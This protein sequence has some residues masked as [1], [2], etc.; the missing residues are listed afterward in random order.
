VLMP[1]PGEQM[2]GCQVATGLTWTC[3]YPSLKK[4]TP[5]ASSITNSSPA[6]SS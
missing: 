5:L 4:N 3:D 1:I 2:P 6:S